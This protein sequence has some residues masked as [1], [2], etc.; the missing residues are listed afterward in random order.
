MV[1]DYGVAHPPANAGGCA[2]KA[3]IHE[4]TEAGLDHSL[5]GQQKRRRLI[6][7]TFSLRVKPK[8]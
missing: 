8:T 4:G 6:A 1:G 3:L 5:G 2:A 7:T